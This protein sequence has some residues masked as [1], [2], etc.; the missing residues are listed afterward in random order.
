MNSPYQRS[1]QAGYSNDQIIDFLEKDSKY[2]EKIKKSREAGYSNDDIGKFLAGQQPQESQQPQERSALEKAGRLGGQAALS[3]AS[4]RALPYEVAVAPLNTEGFHVNAIQERIGGDLEDLYM[5]KAYGKWTDQDE[6]HLL[7]LQDQMKNPG[8]I[9]KQVQEQGI[10]T[11]LSIKGLTEKATELD[12]KPEGLAENIANWIGVI[13]D[14]KKILEAGLNP[15]ELIKAIAPT[16]KETLRGIGAGTALQMAEEGEYGPIGSMAIVVLADL[17]GGKIA[18]IGKQTTELLSKPKQTIANM[19]SKFTKT[20]EKALQQ[21][22]IK[23]FR[24][25]GIQADL[26][27]LTGSDLVKWTQTKLAQSG[28]TGKAL[29]DLKERT[30]QQI[31]NAYEALADSLGKAKYTTQ[32]EAGE[33]VQNTIKG[34]READLSQVREMYKKSEQ[35]LLSNASVNSEKIAQEITKIEKALQPGK[36]KSVEQSATLEVLNKIKKDIYETKEIP[37]KPSILDQYGKVLNESKAI[38]KTTLKNA[39]VK[40]L[41]NDKIAL[42]DI[43]NYE[44]QGGT[45]QLLKGIVAELDR[46]IISHGK[47][48]PAFAN[49]YVLSNKRFSEHAK[50]FRN[51]N[52]NSIMNAADPALVMTK[53]NTVQGIKDLEKSLQGSEG[54]KL[55]NELKRKK[56]D[57]VI[58]NNLIDSTTKQ[59]K[60]GTFSKLLEKGKNR[61]II[62]E[63]LGPK[64]FVRLERLQKNAGRLA[65]ANAKF[66][67]ASQSGSTAIDAAVIFKGMND[68]VNLLYGN[69]WGLMKTTG[70]ITGAKKLSNLMADPEFLK[71]VE[72][73]ILTAEKGK[74]TEIIKSFEKISPYILEGINQSNK[75]PEQ[76]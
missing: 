56:L 42:N 59:A 40:D 12:L 18:D 6:K 72:D 68:F 7:A 74:P 66:Y 69:P 33:A 27:T 51:K 64:A 70:G 17:A 58:G 63:I 9:A 19:A 71:L 76:K 8:K 29:T 65:E 5:Q 24:N 52:I 4:M 47:D 2:S 13:K 60:L 41:I 34:I 57:D 39:N 28:F 16:G 50:T 35:S 62:K 61:E 1:V 45:K 75:T 53:M 38:T 21:E 36:L 73:A 20:D 55:F 43:I 44:V 31:K 67:N 48:N 46:A 3:F 49:N 15:K 37:A 22:I 25:A 54:K 10:K 32:H 11:D 23:D 14:P 26:G 30:T